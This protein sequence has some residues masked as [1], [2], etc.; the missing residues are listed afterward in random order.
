MSV[1]LALAPE[2]RDERSIT[3]AAAADRLGCDPTT[4][5]SLLRQGALAGFRIGKSE[6]PS[7]VRVKLWSIVEWEQRHSIEAEIPPPRRSRQRS[8]RNVADAEA[9][10]RLRAWGV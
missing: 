5:R 7:G 3:V 1:R 8:T 6:A 9:A 10:A 4:I 2:E